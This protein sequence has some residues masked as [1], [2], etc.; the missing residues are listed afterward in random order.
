MYL[1][2]YHYFCGIAR[3]GVLRSIGGMG[4]VMSNMVLRGGSGGEGKNNQ[5]S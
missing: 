2:A 1:F 4:A 5:I 3:G